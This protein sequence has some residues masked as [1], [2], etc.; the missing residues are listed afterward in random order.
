M[1]KWDHNHLCSQRSAQR[2]SQ[3][4]G[5]NSE[6]GS[7]HSSTAYASLPADTHSYTMQEFAQRYFRKP[8]SP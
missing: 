6:E 1:A 4:F 2:R 3:A 7:Q 5:D 8:Q